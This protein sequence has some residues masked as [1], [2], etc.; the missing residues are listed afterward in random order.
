MT[1]Q[2]KLSKLRQTY[3]TANVVIA[4]A[5]VK[6]LKIKSTDKRYPSAVEWAVIRIDSST[7]ILSARDSKEFAKDN[8]EKRIGR[9]HKKI[10]KEIENL[11]KINEVIEGIRPVS[12]SKLDQPISSSPLPS[13]TATVT[14]KK[15]KPEVTLESN[16][17]RVEK[18][19]SVTLTW[20]SKNATKI[21]RTNIPG[22]TTK[23][24]VN[25]FIEVEDIRRRRDFY[26]IVESSSGDTAESKVQTLVETQEYKKQK[27]KGLI[28][29]PPEVK[30]PKEEKKEE[31]SKPSRL[32]RLVSPSVRSEPEKKEEK[33]E[34]VIPHESSLN[35]NVLLSI[36][37]T[38][39]NILKILTT[40]LKLNQ[41]I[42]DRD[43][44]G[45]EAQFRLKREER[46][47]E[48]R[49]IPGGDLIA[50]GA[51]QMLSPFKTIIDKIVNFIFF[52]FLGR[53]FTEIM[54]W[55]ND[56]KNKEKVDAIGRFIKDFWPIIAAV[57]LYFLTPLGGFINGTISFLS[58]TIKTLRLL[59]NLVNR[60]IF[61]KGVK[62]GA[63]PKAVPQAKQ[64]V[65][66]G[67]GGTTPKRPLGSGPKITGD[68]LKPGFK[69]KF[70][71]GNLLSMLAG[72]GFDAGVNLLFG[73]IREKR[74]ISIAQKI[75]LL[76]ENKKKEAIQKIE[77]QIKIQEKLGILGNPKTIDELK[78]ILNYVNS[79]DLIPQKMSGGGTVFSG[80]VTGKDGK[81][82]SGAGKD[83]QAFPVLGG[84]I[85][86]LQPG[87]TVLQPGAREA[88]IKDKGFDVLSYNKGKNAN[89]PVSIN[90][91]IMG[92][93]TGGIVGGT[94]RNNTNLLRPQARIIFD[95]LVK[96]GL[97]PIAAAGVISNIGVETGYTYD[98]STHQNEGGP[99]RGLVQ[100]EKGGRFDT[101]RIN[102]NSFARS[103][104]KPWTDLNTQIDFILH[105]LNTHLE[106]KKVKERINKAK[107]IE[108]STRIFLTDYEKAGTPHIEDR[109]KVAKQLVGAGYLKPSP[110]S[111]PKQPST[112]QTKKEQKPGILQPLMDFFGN[113]KTNIQ[114]IFPKKK[115]GGLIE[116]NS[117]EMLP[118]AQDNILMRAEKG[119][120]VIP[121][122]ATEKVGLR[123][124]DAISSLDP[125]F[126]IK[127]SDIDINSPRPLSRS[128]YGSAPITLPPITQGMEQMGSS[129]GSG[130]PIPVFSA[131][132]A[133]GMDARSALADIYGI[134]G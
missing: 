33:K 93:N 10:I 98:P 120:Y 14:T 36:D 8:K 110:Q 130:T 38:L 49:G 108:T 79:P 16:A 97:T 133:S 73:N 12:T 5:F 81:K 20:T 35:N 62:S 100:W 55:M 104:G 122:I 113:V 124:L 125:N 129:P 30:D 82:V 11:Y 34:S 112:S 91:N 69:I 90:A 132:P 52:T 24:P 4:E 89:N 53:A 58:G 115:Y 83:T 105:E 74:I 80:M 68:V 77:K 128:S 27:E 23:T 45:A 103:R 92:M 19:G 106:Y 31:E 46:M 40:Q 57:A 3:G 109:L 25:S 17:Q 88:I 121:K 87:E 42:F 21:K 6:L 85:A 7:D 117:G 63:G 99:G 72:F 78:S 76:P 15:V 114:N 29:E 67:N 84:G 75:N 50:K 43:R 61:K 66:T 2:K 26:I 13:P 102:L 37:K 127:K 54:N 18:G 1:N 107:D 32:T 101:D 96:G 39:S 22:V 111:K 64:K 94:P 51:E 60:L 118:Y 59:K 126:K 9:V 65:T 47:E 48:S 116:R 131:T 134:V 86:V 71:G 70:S 28:D 123:V 56:P 41:G 95:R 119:E 44:R